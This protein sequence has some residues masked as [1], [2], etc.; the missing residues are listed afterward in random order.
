M[1]LLLLLLLLRLLHWWCMNRC[2]VRRRRLQCSAVSGGWRLDGNDIIRVSRGAL[3]CRR[4]CS[5]SDAKLAG[6]RD[7]NI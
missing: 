1:L 5:C 7:I 6:W 2:A 4:G 3:H